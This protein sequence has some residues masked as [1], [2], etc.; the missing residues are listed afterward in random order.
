MTAAD[1][2]ELTTEE[3][4]DA[5]RAVVLLLNSGLC[6]PGDRRALRA[7]LSRIDKRVRDLWRDAA[8]REAQR[9]PVSRRRA[10]TSRRT[11]ATA[12]IA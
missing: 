12:S 10:G 1:A 5:R 11:Q 3:L 9:P 4:A 7:I 2:R 6:A 8:Q